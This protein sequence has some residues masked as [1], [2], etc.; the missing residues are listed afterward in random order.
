MTGQVS[1]SHRAPGLSQVGAARFLGVNDTTS[2]RWIAGRHPI[3]DSVAMLLRL[4]IRSLPLRPPPRPLARPAPRIRQRRA[5]CWPR[6]RST[7]SRGSRRVRTES[8]CL[9]QSQQICDHSPALCS[10][11]PKLVPRER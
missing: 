2:R 5:S 9:A 11:P 3:P 10:G 4:M 1:R 6:E 7:P 8:R